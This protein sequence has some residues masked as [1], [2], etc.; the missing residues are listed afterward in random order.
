M[1]VPSFEKQEQVMMKSLSLFGRL[2]IKKCI[3]EFGMIKS[4]KDF[5]V[6]SVII[7]S[8]PVFF[9]LNRASIT[10]PNL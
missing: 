7:S 8:R 3:I 10:L 5:L 9:I 2:V 1:K 4:G 6:Q